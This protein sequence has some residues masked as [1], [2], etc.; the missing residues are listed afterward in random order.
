MLGCKLEQR[1]KLGLG[2]MLE[3]LETGCF[4]GL[5]LSF[6]LPGFVQVKGSKL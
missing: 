5:E 3:Q 4:Q 6:E 1:K 2:H